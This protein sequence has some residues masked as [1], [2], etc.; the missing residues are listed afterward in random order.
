MSESDDTS[1]KTL[2]MN[3][4]QAFHDQVATK[5]QRSL[6]RPLPQMEVRVKNLTIEAEVIVGRHEDGR[7][8]PTLTHTIKT[9]ALK[10]SAKKHVMH[11]TILRNFSGVF[12]PGTLTLVL[13][14]PSSGKSSLMKVLSGRFPQ[15]K[16]VTVTGEVTYNGVPQSELRGRLPQFVTYVDQHDVHFPMLSV[17]ETLEFAHAFTGGEMLRQGEDLLTNGSPEENLDALK[18]VQTLFKHFPDIIIEQ[19]GLQ[20]CQ[21]TI[22]GNAMLRGVSGGERKRV[23]TGEMEFGMKYMTLMDEISTGLDSATAFD[24]ITTQRS[25]ATT[26]G[27]TVV[28]SLL[29]PSPEIFALFDNVLLLNAGE[30]MYHGP[31]NRVLS[32]FEN[33]GFRCPPHRD[34][35]DFL[36]DLG[37]N[38]QVKYQNSLP[39]GMTK[40]P[41]WS[42]EFGQQFEESMIYHDT[43][44]RLDNPLRQDLVD[45]VMTYMDLMPEFHQPFQDNALTIFKR[46]MII[47]LRNVAFIKGRGIMVI[48]VALLYG[49]TFY[50]VPPTKAQ[51]AL[52]VLFQSV[53]FLGFGQAAQIPTYCEAR[54]IFYK[55]R[56]A[57][58][59]RTPAY[60]VANSLS[61]IP[62]IL[63]ET[64]VFGSIVYYMCGFRSSV[65][66][67]VIFEI[68]ILLTLLVF[69][70]WFFFITA[71]SPNLHIAKPVAMVTV[72]FFVIFAGFIVPK[73]EI[74]D[75]FVWIYWIN[76]IAWC[77]RGFAVNQYRSDEFEVCVY[78]GVDYCTSYQ[79]TMGEYALSLY[80]VPS[81][82][83]WVWL[84]MVFLVATYVIFL[85]LGSLVLEYKRYESPEHIILT[86]QPTKS[87]ESDEYALATTP[88]SARKIPAMSARI[89]DT[90]ALSV[91]ATKKFDP[92]VIAFQ[93]LWYSVAD[94][95]NP[96]EALTL[97]KGISGYALPGSITALMGSTGAGKTT[98]MD[99][100]AGRKTGGTV[101]GKIMLNGYE[102]SDLAIRRSTG[103]CEQ[104]DIHSE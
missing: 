73:D 44:T 15:E 97:L 66:A 25:I 29:Q 92:V 14:Q 99:V 20:N 11:K 103:Y 48:I 64:L 4:V 2:L 63:A 33:L 42:V 78:E 79:M 80:D 98:L 37:T 61:Q 19:L 53:V 59:I 76:P 16:N 86:A 22:I 62:W 67:F 24:I 87:I 72:L 49:S 82:K 83:S 10:L 26:L 45:N 54:E 60:V 50:Q 85:L 69:A 71:V 104:M 52:G 31:R 6:G 55:Q 9:A 75:Y 51:V 102:A 12:E 95:H 90:V 36:L 70:A 65:A 68:L 39:A 1:T 8:L 58:F 101:Q 89:N 18:I 43:L 74:P 35:A 56:G 57:N 38:Q 47:M 21:D 93:D 84:A 34:T 17:K 5:L 91:R 41:R 30:V 13:G 32:Y 23:T 77:V 94:P 7:E 88:T 28:I 81:D 3:G 27:K 96:K 46:Q 40:H 100:I